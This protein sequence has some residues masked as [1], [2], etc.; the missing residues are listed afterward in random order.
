MSRSAD[1]PARYIGST[2]HQLASPIGS[3]CDPMRSLCGKE[4]KVPTSRSPS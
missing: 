4:K 2:V 1:R 3:I